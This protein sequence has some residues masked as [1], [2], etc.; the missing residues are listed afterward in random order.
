M[1]GS[2]HFQPS[3]PRRKSL[4]HTQ[5]LPLAPKNR[6]TPP[7][8][9][10]TWRHRDMEFGQRISKLAFHQSVAR[11]MVGPEPVT[12][13]VPVPE[14]QFCQGTVSQVD[15][16]LPRALEC[17]MGY[18]AAGPYNGNAVKQ[19]RHFSHVAAQA[20]QIGLLGGPQ[21]L[22][23]LAQYHH[24]NRAMVT[25]P[26]CERAL[27]AQPRAQGWVGWIGMNSRHGRR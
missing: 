19:Q 2:A 27:G 11:K 12:F 7:S 5:R 20:M 10:W 9:Q 24:F 4:Q 26:C 15:Q 16:R 3:N 6:T 22:G 23:A 17:A 14:Q 8:R 1:G 25:Q 18:S 13:H 21:T